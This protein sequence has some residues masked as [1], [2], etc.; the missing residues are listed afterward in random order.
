[1]ST[2]YS[3]PALSSMAAGGVP[4]E[5]LYQRL[6]SSMPPTTPLA[7]N[8][9]QIWVISTLEIAVQMN[10][11]THVVSQL[12]SYALRNQ[13]QSASHGEGYLAP[14]FVAYPVPIT[15]SPPTTLASLSRMCDSAV[16]AATLQRDIEQLAYRLGLRDVSIEERPGFVEIKVSPRSPEMVKAFQIKRFG[17]IGVSDDCLPNIADREGLMGFAFIEAGPQ[18]P[19]HEIRRASPTHLRSESWI[20]GKPVQSNLEAVLRDEVMSAQLRATAISVP[21]EEFYFRDTGLLVSC[22]L[23]GYGKAVA[24]AH[25]MAG[26][27]G[28]GTDVAESFTFTIASA[29]QEF[30]ARAGTVQV[31]LAGDG[32]LLALPDR[33]GDDLGERV[34]RVLDAWRATISVVEDLDARA[35]W[36]DFHVGSRIALHYGAWR[37]GR[38]AGPISVRA[39]FDGAAVID[40]VR[41]EQGLADWT[42]R[43]DPSP[44]HAGVLSLELYSLISTGSLPD[45]LDGRADMAVKEFEGVGVIFNMEGS[46]HDRHDAHVS[47]SEL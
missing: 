24:R 42:R 28:S 14:P 10:G 2:T 17:L 11:K 15:F 44:L 29:L 46:N 25:E 12:A 47:R 22:D 21:H 3:R 40:V 1:M 34:A 4:Y 16:H 36:A 8:P 13:R 30:V 45:I 5:G 37:Y 23:G 31:Q 41:F 39:G 35:G 7:A 38:V 19:G 6:S 20:A 27:L 9:S 43:R 32:V 26:L 33:V 18:G